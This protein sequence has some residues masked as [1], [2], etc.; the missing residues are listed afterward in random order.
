[1]WL[2]EIEEQKMECME[3]KREGLTTETVTAELQ[4][5]A[6]RIA[7]ALAA[8]LFPFQPYALITQKGSGRGD[9]VAISSELAFVVMGF[10][11]LLYSDGGRRRRGEDSTAAYILKSVISILAIC[12]DGWG[13]GPGP[14]IPRKFQ[15]ATEGI[16]K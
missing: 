6:F 9:R 15:R 4:H 16:F 1:V 7:P 3:A 13:A 8:I 10:S 14:A 12:I 2:L 11:A 5:I